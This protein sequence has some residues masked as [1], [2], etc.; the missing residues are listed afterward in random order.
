MFLGLLSDVEIMSLMPY[1]E[2][3]H[4]DPDKMDVD[5]NRLSNVCSDM[6]RS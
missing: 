5:D 3:K 2:V 1:V 6:I 4:V